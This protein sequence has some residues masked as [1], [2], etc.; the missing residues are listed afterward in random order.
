M[1]FIFYL[2]LICCL[3]YSCQFTSPEQQI[4]GAW[5]VDSTYTFYNGF[6]FTAKQDGQDWAV[7]L[8][9]ND[10]TVKEV[11]FST[12]RQHRYELVSKDSLVFT[13]NM[14]NVASA[15]KILEIDAD[16]LKLYKAKAPV[17]PGANQ[18]RYEIR[19]YSRTTPP[20]NLDA[21]QPINTASATE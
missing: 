18:K 9:E 12:Y 1:R 5:Q 4:I 15:F 10:G 6:G 17:F 16:H 14:G 19:Y 8:Y 11:K 21:F 13:D 2:L 20:S 7:L 3:S